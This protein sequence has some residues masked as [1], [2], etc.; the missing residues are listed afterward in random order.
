MKYLLDKVKQVYHSITGTSSTTSTN[1]IGTMTTGTSTGT[2]TVNNPNYTIY[3]GGNVGIGTGTGNA[4]STWSHDDGNAAKRK[5]KRRLWVIQHNKTW[6]HEMDDDMFESVCS[7]LTSEL[8]ADNVVA[9]EIIFN[10]KMCLKYRKYFANNFRYKLEPSKFEKIGFNI[11]GGHYTTS[12]NSGYYTNLTG[13]IITTTSGTGLIN[14][15]TT[16]GT[17]LISNKSAK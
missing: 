17:T 2:L 4:Y 6:T 1:T 16:S 9:K 8:K 7:M 14:S 10:S 3:S 15:L 13:T 12:I 11:T 5:L